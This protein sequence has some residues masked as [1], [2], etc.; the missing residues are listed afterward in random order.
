MSLR[1][2][3]CVDAFADLFLLEPFLA[4]LLV[5]ERISVELPPIRLKVPEVSES[6]APDA[7]GQI[8][9][10]LHHGDAAGVNRTQVRILEEPCQVTLASLLQ[11]LQGIAGEAHSQVVLETHIPQVTLERGPCDEVLSLSLV[12]FDLPQSSG[13]RTRLALQDKRLHS[14]GHGLGSGGSRGRM[15][16]LA[17]LLATSVGVG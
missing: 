16:A 14:F 6:V 1:V 12:P 10:L 4:D 11:R 8:H 9:V 17:N 3:G 5:D 15:C 13:T 7:A 2:S